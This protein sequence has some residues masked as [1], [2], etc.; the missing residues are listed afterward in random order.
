[1]APHEG[2]HLRD[3]RRFSRREIL[4][5]A[6]GAAGAVGAAGSLGLTLPWPPPARASTPVATPEGA[7]LALL[8]DEEARRLLAVARALFPH[9]VLPDTRYR[10]VVRLL[11]ARAAADPEAARRLREGLEQ[12]PSDFRSRPV[13]EQEA[14]LGRLADTPFFALVRG[15]TVEGLYEQPEVWAVLGYPGPSAPFG[16]YLERGLADIDWLPRADT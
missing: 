13:A 7:A 5:G 9:D 15:A 16:G 3:E 8:G 1:M 12:I 10:E 4:R 6:L 2:A 14:L 11:D